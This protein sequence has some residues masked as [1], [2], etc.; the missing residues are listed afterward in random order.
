VL[1]EVMEK[2]K[3]SPLKKVSTDTAGMRVAEKLS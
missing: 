2:F 3:K 1:N